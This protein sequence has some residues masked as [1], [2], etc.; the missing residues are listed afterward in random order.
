VLSLGPSTTF[1]TESC[2]NGIFSDTSRRGTVDPGSP[3]TVR[4]L[5][6]VEIDLGRL[7]PGGASPSA[8]RATDRITLNLFPDVCVIATREHVTDLGPGRVQWIGRVEGPPSGT[9]ILVVDGSLVVGTVTID[10]R[11]FRISYLGDGVHAVVDVD[12]SAFPRD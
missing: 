10:G 6:R 4:R 12:Q 8:A 9:A 2:G 11:V 5:R 1:A 3:R 7:F